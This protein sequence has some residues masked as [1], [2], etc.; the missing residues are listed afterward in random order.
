MGLTSLLALPGGP[1]P[2][3]ALQRVFKATLDLLVAYKNQLAGM[4]CLRS[5]FSPFGVVM[6][7]YIPFPISIF[8]AEAAKETEVD[9]EDDMNGL[10]SDDDDDDD[11]SDGEMGMDAT[12]DG[13]EAESRKL[14]KLA[15]QV[16]QVF[17]STL[18]CQRCLCNLCQF[19]CFVS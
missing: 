16:C 6:F 15:A 13:E 8:L 4:F 2:D 1:F 7:T 9:Y 17:G 5:T 18:L 11:G 3:E 19:V 14:A 12:E 10:E